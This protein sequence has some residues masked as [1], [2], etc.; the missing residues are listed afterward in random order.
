MTATGYSSTTIG[1]PP[2]AI[3]FPP[4]A[5]VCPSDAVKLRA[6]H[7]T[8]RFFFIFNSKRPAQS[9]PSFCLRRSLAFASAGS[10]R[11]NAGLTLATL[12]PLAAACASPTVFFAAIDLAGAYPVAL[13]W[14]LAPPLMALCVPRAP[15]PEE[16]A[17][18]AAPQSPAPAAPQPPAPAAPQSP[19]P[20]APQPPARTVVLVALALASAAFVLCNAWADVRL[21]LGWGGS[22]ARWG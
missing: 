17:A 10:A 13:L 5:V 9:R 20:A 18:P 15:R 8:A 3:R 22:T 7:R 19:A 4:I 11:A 1:Y 6:R 16:G 2:T 14:G 12:V 21:A